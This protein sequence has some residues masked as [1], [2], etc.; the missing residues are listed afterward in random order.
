MS[1]ANVLSFGVELEIL[2]G[3][4]LE[5]QTDPDGD[6]QD[7]APVLTVPMDPV[8]GVPVENEV[9]YIHNHI[10]GKLRDAGLTLH[11]ELPEIPEAEQNE[12]I[13][14]MRRDAIFGINVVQDSSV[15]EADWGGYR[16]AN[17]EINSSAAWTSNVAF[18]EIQRIIKVIRHHYRV[19]VNSTCGLHVH[20]GNGLRPFDTQTLRRSAALIWCL[21]P[22]LADIHPPQRRRGQYSL[23][24]R[25]NSRLA[26]G[27]LTSDIITESSEF[28]QDE[29]AKIGK[30]DLGNTAPM[31]FYQSARKRRFPESRLATS[32]ADRLAQEKLEDM[33]PEGYTDLELKDIPADEE[34]DVKYALDGAWR[35]LKA[36]TTQEISALMNVTDA[37]TSG[38]PNYSFTGYMDDMSALADEWD[39]QW[40]C[41]DGKLTI[42]FREAIGSL[43]AEWV[44]AWARICAGVM[45]FT[46]NASPNEFTTM[47][48]RLAQTQGDF[49]DS[50]AGMYD[51]IDFLDDI[52]CC[53]EAELLETRLQNR[54]EFWFPCPKLEGPAKEELRV[55]RVPDAP[56]PRGLGPAWVPGRGSAE[57]LWGAS[58]NSSSA[59]AKEPWVEEP[60]ICDIYDIYGVSDRE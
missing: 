27:L 41:T 30:L 59:P 57:G 16:F 51:A 28:F 56:R 5:G 31:A 6:N 52:G 35:L 45:L 54:K 8:L 22:V 38:K 33:Y 34:M 20:V 43:D 58:A 10:K 14:E 3:Y 37:M 39:Y 24:I 46:Q 29:N 17:I 18:T 15:H 11:S 26:L 4:I 21:D 19:R 9:V 40:D 12:T 36:E 50:C 1:Q 32:R 13:D 60:D 48:F 55:P 23:S 47:L 2:V 7:L 25:E 53:A 44:C 42:E 49:G